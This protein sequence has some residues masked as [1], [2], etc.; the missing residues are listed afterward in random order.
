MGTIFTLS[1][2]KKYYKDEW[3]QEVIDAHQR[4]V[5]WWLPIDVAGGS[6]LAPMSRHRF[7]R[8]AL[9]MPEEEVWNRWFPDYVEDR[10]KKLNLK[11]FVIELIE[12][13]TNGLIDINYLTCDPEWEPGKR[14]QLH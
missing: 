7:C 4:Y 8:W 12:Q 9:Y 10:E 1:K 5:D 6:F 14:K 11:R 2:M 3:M 13:H